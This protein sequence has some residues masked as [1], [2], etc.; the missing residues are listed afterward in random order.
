MAIWEAWCPTISLQKILDDAA[1]RIAKA[2]NK[3]AV[4]HGPGAALVMTC[5][6]IKWTIVSATHFV[7]DLGEHLHLLLD[8][9]NVIVRRCFDAV[10]RRRWR[11]VERQLPQLAANGAGR[12]PFMEPIWQ[13]LNTKSNDKDWTETH[14]GCLRSAMANRQYPQTR[15]MMCGWS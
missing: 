6:R 9:P 8:P 7:T 4:C 14:N 3:W 11:R 2:R 12:G 5:E 1:K 10:Q 15:V 13:L